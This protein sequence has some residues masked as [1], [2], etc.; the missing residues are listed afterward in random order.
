VGSFRD[1][2]EDRTA[3]YK[4]RWDNEMREHIANPPRFD[5]VV[6]AVRRH[7]RR[8]DLLDR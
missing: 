7:L 6:R 1:R 2:F 8:A 4:P 5:D 3:R